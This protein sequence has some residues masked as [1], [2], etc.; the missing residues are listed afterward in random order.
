[1]STDSTSHRGI[2]LEGTHFTV[3]ATSYQE[4]IDITNPANQKW[5]TRVFG[6]EKALDH[7]AA[8][9][10]CGLVNNIN[11]IVSSYSASP[12]TKH[13][14]D[15]LTFNKLFQKLNF[16]SGDH[17]ADGKKFRALNKDLK[18]SIVLEILGAGALH[19]PKLVQQVADV[20]DD[21]VQ[22]HLA[23]CGIENL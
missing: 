2:T 21:E 22:L 4:D 12:L 10:H 5:V 17:V 18:D 8:E 15:H 14:N 11:Q 13:L 23:S 20:P 16:Q 19:D 6:V 3:K 1:L 9:Q 7:T